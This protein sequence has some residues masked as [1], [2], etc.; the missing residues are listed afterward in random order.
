MDSAI[1]HQVLANTQ[2][3]DREAASIA[4]RVAAAAARVEAGLAAGTAQLDD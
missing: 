4:A 1:T 3:A 2:P